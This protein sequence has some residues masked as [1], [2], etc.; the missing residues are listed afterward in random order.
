M[1][2]VILLVFIF[3]V[4]PFISQAQSDTVKVII[5]PNL[6]YQTL[7]GFGGSLAYY[8]NWFT[9][10][11]KKYEIFKLIFKGLN[12][13]LLRTMVGYGDNCSD[14]KEFASSAKVN[15]GH[16]ISILAT[17]WAPVDSLKN[18]GDRKNGG[19]LRYTLVNGK[20]VFDYEG[21]ANW[22]VDRLRLY[23]K[24]NV[25][26]DYISIQ[27]EPNMNVGYECCLFEASEVNN[28]TDTT[29]MR[30]S[31]PKAL[32]AVVAAI[33]ADTNLIMPRFVGPEGVG[34][35][36]SDV[37]LVTRKAD[38]SL[39][40]AIAYHYYRGGTKEDADTY[41]ASLAATRLFA[42]KHDS[43]PLWQTEYSG[44]GTW[45]NEALHIYNNIVLAN[46]QA[47][48]Y[49]GLIYP[50]A[51]ALIEIGNPW[52]ST[53]YIVHPKY[54]SMKHFSFFAGKGYLRVDADSY[55]DLRVTAFVSPQK[56]KLAVVVINKSGSK[57]YPFALNPVGYATDRY[58]VYRSTE[59]RK[60]FVPAADSL[61]SCPA[62]SITT[63]EFTG[64]YTSVEPTVY[65]E[66]QLSV[67]PNPA[68]DLVFVH[69]YDQRRLYSVIDLGGRTVLTGCY[70]ADSGIPVSGLLK[71]YYFIITS[72]KRCLPFIKN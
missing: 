48:L 28:Q 62:G 30:A 37:Q 43:I 72:D 55:E 34:C 6:H 58:V 44:P 21:F 24:N 71:G 23:K 8:S 7:D 66:S 20:P 32:R 51:G 45:I 47:Y 61:W 46:A 13:D 31:Y 11:Q 40:Y 59:D 69:G 33:A 65:D 35:I 49:W 14:L 38:L 56:D 2:K 15:L 41:S 67:F 50:D 68:T 42:D 63:F 53:N 54:Y 60:W 19:T 25:Y 17:S 26:P 27:N 39:M 5:R 22:W 12:M 16:K 64:D 36:A 3:I 9:A 29:L 18:N 52:S 70:D 4:I 57:A 1:K 10:H